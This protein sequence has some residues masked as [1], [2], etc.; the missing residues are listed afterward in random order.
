MTK[1]DPLPTF[2]PGH[3][4]VRYQII[5]R[6]FWPPGGLGSYL[7]R[8]SRMWRVKVALEGRMNLG[9]VHDHAGRGVVAHLLQREG[10]RIMY[11]ASCFRACASA[12]FTCTRL[13]TEKPEWRQASRRFANSALMH[14]CSISSPSTDS[15]SV[16]VSASSSSAG[17]RRCESGQIPHRNST[18]WTATPGKLKL[19]A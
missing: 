3:M 6:N 11:R 18:S 12:A 19:Y 2:E 4:N 9:A 7:P 17:S 15:R 13:C 8:C 14:S 5:E 16:W 10:A 1:T